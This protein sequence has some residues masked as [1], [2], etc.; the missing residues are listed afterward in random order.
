M[1]YRYTKDIRIL[2]DFE[3]MKFRKKRLLSG[4]ISVILLVIFFIIRSMLPDNSLIFG[5]T[6][7]TDFRS[8]WLKILDLITGGFIVSSLVASAFCLYFHVTLSESKKY[9]GI[10]RYQQLSRN[11]LITQPPP[12]YVSKEPLNL[13]TPGL[14]YFI[15]GSISVLYLGLFIHFCLKLLGIV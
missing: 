2:N 3:E 11:Y 4:I 14:Y 5:F 13:F 15:V 10:Y 7:E 12:R 6:T 1:S 8:I 9:E